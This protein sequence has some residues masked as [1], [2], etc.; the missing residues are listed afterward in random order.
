MFL[1]PFSGSFLHIYV[2][3]FLNCFAFHSVPIS[4]SFEPNFEMCQRH[5]H[6]QRRPSYC[7]NLV[8]WTVSISS[9]AETEDMCRKRQ[10][11]KD[12]RDTWGHCFSSVTK[13][14]STVP[15]TYSSQILMDC[16][17]LNFRVFRKIMINK[18]S[19]IKFTKLIYSARITCP[20][21]N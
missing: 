12:S 16:L 3:Y 20:C 1:I 8:F 21:R 14:I 13:R 18:N 15:L 19:Y 2:L 6:E 7:R 5:V 4:A 17:L 11:T 9:V 10:S